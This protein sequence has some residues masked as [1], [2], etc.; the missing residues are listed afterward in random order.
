MTTVSA[1]HPSVWWKVSLSLCFIAGMTSFK[2]RKHVKNVRSL[3]L[4]HNS[5][6]FINVLTSSFWVTVLIWGPWI[7][8]FKLLT[9]LLTYLLTHSMVQNIIWKPDCH[10]AYQ[11]NPAFFMKPEGSSPCSQKPATGPYPQPAE[12]SSSHRFLF[13]FSIA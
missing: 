7:D 8:L 11:K 4:L 1:K 3:F 10:S 6:F 9:Y 12:S 13:P 5:N 2:S